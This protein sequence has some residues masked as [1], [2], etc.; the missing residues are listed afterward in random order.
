MIVQQFFYLYKQID[1]VDTDS[2]PISHHAPCT[3]WQPMLVRKEKETWQIISRSAHWFNSNKEKI[4]ALE[5]QCTEQ[6]AFDIYLQDNKQH[7][8]SM[9]EKAKIIERLHKKYQHPLQKISQQYSHILDLPLG[10]RIL[11]DHLR[12]LQFNQEYSEKVN[13]LSLKNA[14]LL[15]DFK[16][17]EQE[18]LFQLLTNMKWNP[19]KQKEI[20]TILWECTRKQKT[21]VP[22]YLSNPE[23]Q[24]ILEQKNA[25]EIFRTFLKQQK[26]PIYYEMQKQIENI[27]QSQKFK[28]PIKIEPT[29]AFEK[30]DYQ[31]TFTIQ[32]IQDIDNVIET[33]KNLQQQDTFTKLFHISS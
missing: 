21:S 15:L 27:L 2:I 29:I 19:N 22:K 26:N 3:T 10:I 8:F 16:Q 7:G 32:N 9:I 14:L 5:I 30:K 18:C 28:H 23:I 24:K 12:L 6:E 17:E 1:I 13:Q 4:P 31:I 33:F 20:L 11:S 25:E